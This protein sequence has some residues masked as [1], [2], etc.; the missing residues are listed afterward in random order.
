MHDIKSVILQ[1]FPKIYEPLVDGVISLSGAM[2][3]DK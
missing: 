1:R 3:Y 2:S